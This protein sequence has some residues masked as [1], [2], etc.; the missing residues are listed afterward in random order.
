MIHEERKILQTKI[1]FT[2]PF[3]GQ[4]IQHNNRE[5]TLILSSTFGVSGFDGAGVDVNI[6]NDDPTD[7]TNHK[8]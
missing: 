2:M 1:F 7:D 5:T 6:I 3:L 8:I 4:T